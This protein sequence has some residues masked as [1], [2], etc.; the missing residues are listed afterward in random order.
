MFLSGIDWI[1]RCSTVF[2][3]CS[4]LLNQ[5]STENCL[6]CVWMFWDWWDLQRIMKSPNVSTSNWCETQLSWF[7]LSCQNNFTESK[8]SWWPMLKWREGKDRVWKQQMSY[9]L[10]IDMTSCH[11]TQGKWFIYRRMCHTWSFLHLFT[12]TCTFTKGWI[13]EGE[14]KCTLHLWILYL[15]HL[16]QLRLVLQPPG[17]FDHGNHPCRPRWHACAL[18]W[19][20][21][22]FVAAGQWHSIW[23]RPMWK[24][25]IGWMEQHCA[26]WCWVVPNLYNGHEPWRS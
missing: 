22:W 24:Q 1:Y 12:R 23:S 8:G 10:Y 6:G 26:W 15:G 2:Q 20:P 21:L 18:L 4:K 3:Q 19:R 9:N 5:V 14:R 7:I 25:A 17:S 16:N 11:I 13:K